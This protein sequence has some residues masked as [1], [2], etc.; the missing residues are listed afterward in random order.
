MR[1]C[2]AYNMRAGAATGSNILCVCLV[3]IVKYIAQAFVFRPFNPIYFAYQKVFVCF[4]FYCFFL[5]KKKRKFI[6]AMSTEI[7]TDFIGYV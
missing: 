4:C 6:L 7:K 3:T 1:P 2:A 5:L